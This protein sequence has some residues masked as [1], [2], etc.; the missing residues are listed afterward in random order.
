M[1]NGDGSGI[2]WSTAVDLVE[3]PES[4]AFEQRARIWR[5]ADA[6]STS[7]WN[8]LKIFRYIQKAFLKGSMN[9]VGFAGDQ[10]IFNL[11]ALFAKYI[12]TEN[13]PKFFGLEVMKFLTPSGT[14]NI[15]QHLELTLAGYSNT[16]QTIDLDYSGYRYLSGNGENRDLRLRK[17]IQEKKIDG[18]IDEWTA[19]FAIDLKFRESHSAIIIAA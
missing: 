2:S 6:T 4:V 8:E 14:W 17:E 18:Q 19:D 16:C 7:N 9:K 10:F 15:M 5:V 3:A 13:D 1:D 12:R 11:N